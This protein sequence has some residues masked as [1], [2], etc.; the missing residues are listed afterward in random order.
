MYFYILQLLANII[1]SLNKLGH[2]LWFVNF[3]C[4]ILMFDAWVICYILE[5]KFEV[6][7]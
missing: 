3:D 5:L 7:L 1:L 6:W 4:N 2:H